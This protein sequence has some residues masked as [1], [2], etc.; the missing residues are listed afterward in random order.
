LLISIQFSLRCVYIENSLTAQ[1]PIKSRERV[2]DEASNESVRILNHDTGCRRTS[3]STSRK[4]LS[5]D[6]DNPIE[7][8]AWSVSQ[9][10]VA[11]EPEMLEGKMIH[12]DSDRWEGVSTPSR[13]TEALKRER[14]DQTTPSIANQDATSSDLDLNMLRDL[15]SNYKQQRA[16]RTRR[17]LE[18]EVISRV[19]AQ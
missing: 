13:E 8:Y 18:E 16:E 6:T 5:R 4:S 2:S 9:T 11:K 10:Q 15:C 12:L 1:A 3:T 14:S 7:L 19:E 17:Q